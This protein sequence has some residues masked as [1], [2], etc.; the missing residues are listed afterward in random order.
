MTSGQSHID[1]TPCKSADVVVTLPASHHH[2]I[3]KDSRGS[4]AHRSQ[5]RVTRAACLTSQVFA[6]RRLSGDVARPQAGSGGP[7]SRLLDLGQ[8]GARSA[9]VRSRLSDETGREAPV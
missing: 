4:R 5:A 2:D 8:P 6:T 9:R 1:L 7:P 3:A